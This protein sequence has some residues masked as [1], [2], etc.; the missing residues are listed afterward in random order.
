MTGKLVMDKITFV[1]SATF[2]SRHISEEQVVFG[3]FS[4]CFLYQVA[5]LRE[6]VS[7]SITDL[8]KDSIWTDIN[9]SEVS[10]SKKEVAKKAT[11]RMQTRGK[12]E[13]RNICTYT[14]SNPR[15]HQIWYGFM[16]WFERRTMAITF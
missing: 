14:Y 13:K 15:T 16:F 12:K 9:N 6:L 11:R 10:S 5:K 4:L 3:T 1:D 8:K 7:C 2:P